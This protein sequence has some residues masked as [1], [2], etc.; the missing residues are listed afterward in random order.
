M[1]GSV[2]VKHVEAATEHVSSTFLERLGEWLFAAQLFTWGL[3]V[4]RPEATFS[5]PPLVPLSR[6][7]SEDTWAAYAMTVGGV[8]LFALFINGWVLPHTYLFRIVCSFLS[9]LAWLTITLGL[10][11]SGQA[12]TGLAVYPWIFLAE[13]VCLWRTGRDYAHWRD[14]HSAAKDA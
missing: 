11:S 14:V 13:M 5:S 8:R 2:I 10:I 3:I 1:P 4:S 6:I 9:V 7:A 12:T